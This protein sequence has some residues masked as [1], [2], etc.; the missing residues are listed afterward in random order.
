MKQLCLFALSLCLSGTLIAQPLCKTGTV[1]FDSDKYFLKPSEEEKIKQLCDSLDGAKWFIQLDGHTDSDSSDQYNIELSKRRNGSVIRFISI[2]YPTL[3]RCFIIDA[4]GEEQPAVSNTSEANKALN[5]RVEIKLIPRQGSKV[6][7]RGDDGTMALI[8]T[9]YLKSCDI[10]NLRYKFT[11]YP[12]EEAANR[13]GIDLVTVDGEQLLTGGM[14]KFELEGCAALEDTCIPATLM[15]SSQSMVPGMTAWTLNAGGSWVEDSLQGVIQFDRRLCRITVPCLGDRKI[16]NCDIRL[17]CGYEIDSGIKMGYTR[18]KYRYNIDSTF[19]IAALNEDDPFF[20]QRGKCLDLPDTLWVL[21]KAAE[22]Y[23]YLRLDSAQLRNLP[24]END[25]TDIFWGDI[26][27]IDT[28]MFS[29]I[30]Y[31]DTLLIL[32]AKGKTRKDIEQLGFY[33]SEYDHT[34]PLEPFKKKKFKSSYLMFSHQLELKGAEDG[35]IGLSY[36]DVKMRY[37]KKKRRLKVKVKKK[38]LKGPA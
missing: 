36:D 17:K 3:E 25:T 38:H 37:K 11:T 7:F 4:Y 2:N 13:D 14:M 33:N 8:D 16:K 9:Q 5:R 18:I 31:N 24:L 19:S 22:K 26:Y 30:L 21:A 27:L 29:P 35:T 20:A 34:F 23:Y 12:T 28:S 10:C 15:M 32:K 1:Y 6:V